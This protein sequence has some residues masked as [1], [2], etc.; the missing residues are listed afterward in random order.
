MGWYYYLQNKIIFLFPAKW[1]H[2][3]VKS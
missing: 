1:W 2:W 3:S